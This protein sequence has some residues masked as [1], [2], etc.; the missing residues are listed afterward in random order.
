MASHV[1]LPAEQGRKET[2]GSPALGWNKAVT[3]HAAFQSLLFRATVLSDEA[4]PHPTSI[5]KNGESFSSLI[6]TCQ[7]AIQGNSKN[8]GQPG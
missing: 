5:L 3:E 2:S 6:G 7:A 1:K 4:S 8:V